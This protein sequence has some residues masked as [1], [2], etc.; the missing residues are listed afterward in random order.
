MK[1]V[2]CFFLIAAIIAVFGVIAYA[3]NDHGSSYPMYAKENVRVRSGPSTEY[4]TIYGLLLTNEMFHV[5]VFYAPLNGV[6]TSFHK[7]V[8]DSSTNIAQ[9]YAANGIN[10][11]I[12]YVNSGSLRKSTT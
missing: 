7:G 11:L 1:R 9:Y 10:Q 12:G 8:P 5:T 6:A 3:D 4:T 2:T